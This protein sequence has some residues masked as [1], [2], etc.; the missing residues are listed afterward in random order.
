[1]CCV[2]LLSV[3]ASPTMA[4]HPHAE[5]QI[6]RLRGTLTKVDVVNRAVEL[7]T[8]DPGTKRPRNVLLFLD[9]KVKLRRGKARVEI[10]DLRPG[11]TVTSLVEIR[12]DAEEAERFFALEI[13]TP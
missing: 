13:Q 2:F 9:K 3:L 8:V 6:V 5:R 7:D 4:G 12:H 10:G 1:M 11:Q